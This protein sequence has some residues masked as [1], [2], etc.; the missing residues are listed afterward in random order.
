MFRLVKC[1]RLNDKAIADLLGAIEILR[2]IPQLLF[3]AAMQWHD[4][5]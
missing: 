1:N 5:N 2:H 4:R 3:F